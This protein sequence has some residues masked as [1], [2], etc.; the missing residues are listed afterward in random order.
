MAARPVARVSGKSV[1]RQKRNDVKRRTNDN[2]KL[3]IF[4]QRA[5]FFPRELVVIAG[6]QITD[7]GGASGPKA[8]SFYGTIEC[9][10]WYCFLGE[11]K[12]GM[13]LDPFAHSAFFDFLPFLFALDG[14]VS[15]GR[16]TS[17][18]TLSLLGFS[19]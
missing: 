8:G 17:A 1:P 9:P 13:P 2:L 5:G 3:S 19:K 16:S 10:L 14:C 18:G 6:S 12:L 4:L 7:K 15:S 11:C